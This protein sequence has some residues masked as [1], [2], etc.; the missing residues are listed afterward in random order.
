MK[1]IKTIAPAKNWQGKKNKESS[2]WQGVSQKNPNSKPL[3]NLPA[4]RVC[5]FKAT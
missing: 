2:F 3:K 1:S 4:K 5:T